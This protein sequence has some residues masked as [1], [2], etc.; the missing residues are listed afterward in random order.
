MKSPDRAADRR[1]ASSNGEP[2]RHDPTTP[3]SNERKRPLADELQPVKPAPVVEDKTFLDLLKSS[4][5]KTFTIVNPESYEH[6]PVGFTI[7]A[8][9]YR[10]KLAGMGQDYLILVTEMKKGK[11]DPGEPVKQFLPISQVKR[12]SMMRTE[13]M[14]HI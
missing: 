7:K 13:R 8:G 11:N 14:L 5:G 1:A 3:P 12:I 6:A 9:Y 10:A 2:R 4:L